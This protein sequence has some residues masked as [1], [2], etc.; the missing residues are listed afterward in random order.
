MAVNSPI[1]P[2]EFSV[3]VIEE[4]APTISESSCAT[5]EPANLMFLNFIIIGPDSSK[6]HC[7]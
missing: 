7:L 1:L 3:S 6:T 4:L 5:A 2:A